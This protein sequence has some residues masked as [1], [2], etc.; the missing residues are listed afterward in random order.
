MKAL[1]V[2]CGYLG[3]RVAG[4]WVEGGG[5]VVALTRS[6]E[7][8][9]ELQAAGIEPVVGDVLIPETL[10]N[11]PD[12]DV[13]LYAV[14]FDR[15]AGVDKRTV[16]VDG[17]RNVLDAIG[18]RVDRF[19]YVSSTSVY[20]Q[21][22]GEWVDEESPTEPVTEGG[23]ICLEAEALVTEY[24]SRAGRFTV[25]LRLAGIY[26]LGRLLT[27]VEALRSG[28]ALA[29]SPEAWLNL[30][31]VDDAAAV[32]VRCVEH[33]TP[34][35][36]YLVADDEPATRGEYY[37]ELAR[38]TGAPPPVFDAG[39]T[40]RHGTGLNKRCRNARVRESLALELAYPTMADGLATSIG[41]SLPG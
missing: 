37:G 32:M 6:K 31:H 17:L 22:A 4:R 36:L 38:L 25:I 35:G 40:P 29:G 26:G 3:E 9:V 11:L 19:L 15:T 14:G 2:G 12:C 21:S 7:R 34:E 24:G 13:L 1:I 33:P 20:G 5:E 16:Y 10:I 8:A 30:I 41:S 27:R 39:Q 18:D 28:K 23:R